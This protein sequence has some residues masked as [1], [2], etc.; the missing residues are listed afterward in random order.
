MDKIYFHE[1]SDDEKQKVLLTKPISVILEEY[2]QPKWCG[3]HEALNGIF[4][5]KDL[6]G[7]T[8]NKIC[9]QYCSDCTQFED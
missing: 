5:C 6:L 4:G 7:I 9:K 8:K 3:Q 2:E 1:L